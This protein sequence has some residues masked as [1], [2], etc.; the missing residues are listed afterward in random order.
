M[1]FARLF[2]IF[3]KKNFSE[4]VLKS[5]KHPPISTETYEKPY[6]PGG[7]AQNDEKYREKQAVCT[8]DRS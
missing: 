4:T 1:D 8:K 2:L 5:Q 3:R 7:D 6:P